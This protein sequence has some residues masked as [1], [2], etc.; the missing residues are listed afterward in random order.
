[1][2][3]HG[4]KLRSCQFCGD[5]LPVKYKIFYKKNVASG[6]IK[7]K[8]YIWLCDNENCPGYYMVENGAGLKFYMLRNYRVEFYY[9]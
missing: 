1:M 6:N 9:D 4:I 7:K 2:N 8:N 3:G 5:S